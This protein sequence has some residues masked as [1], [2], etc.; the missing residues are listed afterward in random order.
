[1]STC[2]VDKFKM[3]KAR[4]LTFIKIKGVRYLF[5]D[6]FSGLTRVSDLEIPK[7]FILSQNYPNP[8]NPTTKIQYFVPIESGPVTLKVYDL[9]GRE[10]TTLVDNEQKP[11]GIYEVNFNASGLSSGTYFY[12][13]RTRNFVERKKMSL[14][15]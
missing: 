3:L 10:I 7:E 13:L 15:K 2:H 11:A 6:S 4:F 14:V 9:L 5:Y 8:F 1:M 12:E